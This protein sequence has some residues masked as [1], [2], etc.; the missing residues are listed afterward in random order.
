MSSGVLVCRGSKLAEIISS[1]F[2]GDSLLIGTILPFLFV[3]TVVVFAL[4]LWRGSS[5][6]DRGARIANW[7]L[8]VAGLALTAYQLAGWSGP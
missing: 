2:A 5:G 6:F 1:I 7:A 3:L 4:N 8:V